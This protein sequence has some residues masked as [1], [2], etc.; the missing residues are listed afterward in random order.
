MLQA[1][2]IVVAQPRARFRR[3]V[4]A[5]FGAF[6]MLAA[7]GIRAC[8]FRRHGRPMIG[9]CTH[10]K[11]MEGRGRTGKEARALY[12]F[13]PP[14]AGGDTGEGLRAAA[15]KSLTSDPTQSLIHARLPARNLSPSPLPQGEGNTS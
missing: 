11:N 3:P 14:L 2:P 1:E 4:E 13:S 15:R 7:A 5:G 12:Y 8:G 10:R 9:V 6:R